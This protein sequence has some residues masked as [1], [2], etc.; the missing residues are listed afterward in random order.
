MNPWLLILL[1]MAGVVFGLDYLFRRKKWKDNSKGEKVSL[2]INMFSCGPY[3]FLAVLGIL[4]GLATGSPETAFGEM[5]Y[6]VT[7]LMAGVYFIIAIVAIISS[8]VLRL[9]GK[10]KASVWV[11]I[12]ALL[13]IVV[14]LTIN[15]LAGEIL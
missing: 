3:A 15:F 8:F 5:V 4:W 7:L 9:L 12:I 2:I 6:A 13:Y 14:I 10:V 1:V 11:N